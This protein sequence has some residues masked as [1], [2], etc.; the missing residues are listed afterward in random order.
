MS[1]DPTMAIRG[2]FRFN[3]VD[4]QGFVNKC[5]RTYPSLI[6]PWHGQ[7]MA[8]EPV[9]LAVPQDFGCPSQGE[10]YASD[11]LAKGSHPTGTEPFADGECLCLSPFSL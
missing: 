4:Y 7:E 8:S 10:D 6:V 1:L 9:V 5:F 3:G 2:F 11:S